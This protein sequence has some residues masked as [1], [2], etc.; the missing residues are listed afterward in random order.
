MQDDPDT[1][2]GL[3]TETRA[4]RGELAR[5]NSQPY[6]QRQNSFW[7]MV[8][9]NFARGLSFGLG[10]VIGATI[11]VAVLVKLLSSIDFIPVIGD[12]ATQIIEDIDARVR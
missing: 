1:P 9:W 7:R 2:G 5:L 6:F 8:S 12:W 3:E 11:L 4:L 10:S